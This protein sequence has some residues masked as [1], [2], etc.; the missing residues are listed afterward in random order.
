[1]NPKEAA[2]SEFYKGLL[3]KFGNDSETKSIIKNQIGL[4]KNKEKISVAD[5]DTVESGIISNQSSK[6]SPL[7]T[8]SFYSSRP[9]S[10]RNT[11]NVHLLTQKVNEIEL[12]KQYRSTSFHPTKKKS[13][14]KPDNYIFPAESQVD[15]Q[16]SA[17]FWRMYSCM[18]PKRVVTD[19]DVW[20]K[21]QKADFIKYK[22]ELHQKSRVK[23]QQQHEYKFFLD[24]QVRQ[25]RR[26]KDS[27]SLQNSLILPSSLKS[28]KKNST[29][30][31]DLD[32]L[33][34]T[35]AVKNQRILRIQTEEDAKFIEKCKEDEKKELKKIIEKRKKNNELS[36]EILKDSVAK[37]KLEMQKTIEERV[38]S[39]ELMNE[40]ISLSDNIELRQRMEVTN[41]VKWAHDEDRLRKLL[42]V[43]QNVGVEDSGNTSLLIGEI[44]MMR[45]QRI[46]ENNK[47]ILQQI[48][49]KIKKNCGV[50]KEK[51]M[52]GERVRIGDLNA[53]KEFEENLAQKKLRESMMRSELDKQISRKR[54]DYIN[55][56]LFT[57]NEAKINKRIFE[58]SLQVIASNSSEN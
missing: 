20:A 31:K 1:M 34:N 15:V 18:S 16:K 21:I 13:P 26:L 5:L 11:P 3:D 17:E 7:T 46:L 42:P 4:L 28:V 41:R 32:E 10:L 55:E 52:D 24:Q 27:D 44:D 6:Y 9:E 43:G 19:L 30:K 12:P 58:S 25:S 40:R 35:K 53:L 33:I 39:R 8:K 57:D 47:I 23:K 48:K 2:L 37:R 14:R 51:I 38:R 49:E 22:N 36:E 50:V 54:Q 45:K 29:F 56:M